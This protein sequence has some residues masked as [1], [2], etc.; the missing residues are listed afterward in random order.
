MYRVIHSRVVAVA[1]ACVGIA[2]A[3]TPI[4][5]DPAWVDLETRHRA[6]VE[7]IV[8][9]W[10]RHDTLEADP[11]IVSEELALERVALLDEIARLEAAL[12]TSRV[13][14]GE[15]RL[16]LQPAKER[17]EAVEDLLRRLDEADF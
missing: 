4:A 2:A 13:D 16:A 7:T 6:A 17:L 12:A 8:D 11:L 1:A 3:C 5:E 9:M 14:L 10:E 15:A